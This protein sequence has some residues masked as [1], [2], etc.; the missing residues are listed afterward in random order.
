M[1]QQVA[2]IGGGG[3]EA[4]AVST[5]VSMSRVLG[6]SSVASEARE[7]SVAASGEHELG[8]GTLRGEVQIA[9]VMAD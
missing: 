8:Q 2:A 7:H 6:G 4:G 1:E 3:G 5:S 9:E